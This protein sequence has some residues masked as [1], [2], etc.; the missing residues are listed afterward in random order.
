MSGL[1]DVEVGGDLAFYLLDTGYWILDIVQPALKPKPPH[2]MPSSNRNGTR[3]QTPKKQTP[4]GRWIWSL[5]LSHM[6]TH[7][8]VPCW[9]FI[10]F[11]LRRM[12]M[13]P[14]LARDSH[15]KIWRSARFERAFTNCTC[16]VE[17][18]A[19]LT[20]LL[21]PSPNNSWVID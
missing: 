20:D 21:T 15:R 9:D 19:D 16:Q 2:G 10:L 5:F 4:N 3:K 1:M 17:D 18:E 8:G 11:A 6:P 7:H 12:H 14:H 13:Q